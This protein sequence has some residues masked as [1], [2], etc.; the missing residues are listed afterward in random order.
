MEEVPGLVVDPS[1]WNGDRLQAVSIQG[2]RSR[3]R[4]KNF[5]L[6]RR[7]ATENFYLG[8]AFQV[9]AKDKHRARECASGDR[10]IVIALLGDGE[11][12]SP[13]KGMCL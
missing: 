6:E 8:L 10:G 9:D 7:V 13:R 11:L 5:H 3:C 1:T 4:D 12:A 2:V